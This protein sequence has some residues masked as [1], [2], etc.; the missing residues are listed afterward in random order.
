MK[1]PSSEALSNAMGVLFARRRGSEI[2]AFSPEVVLPVPMYWLRR[3][4]RTTNSPDLLAERI[5]REL[6]IPL[7]ARLL[8]RQRNTL[9]QKDLTPGMRARNVRGAFRVRA[10]DAVRGKR[11]VLIDDIMTTG[12]TCSEAARALR[13]AGAQA[14]AVA[15]LA[16]A[17]GTDHS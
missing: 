7:L 2:I 16:R 17:E 8:K 9:P 11:V 14:V 10:T 5:G 15:V 12:A 6:G 1:R 3:V 4:V 13:T